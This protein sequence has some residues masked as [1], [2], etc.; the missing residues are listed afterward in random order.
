VGFY[1]IIKRKRKRK[2]VHYRTVLL[3]PLYT[4]AIL[5]SFFVFWDKEVCIYFGGFRQKQFRGYLFRKRWLQMGIC[6]PTIAGSGIVTGESS[7]SGQVTQPTSLGGASG[8]I[9]CLG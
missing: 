2:K 6:V 7:V 1:S 3:T 8:I 4:N 9:G 5:D